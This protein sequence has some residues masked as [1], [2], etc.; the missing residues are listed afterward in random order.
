MVYMQIDNAVC[1]DNGLVRLNVRVRISNKEKGE[2]T[3]WDPGFT[4]HRASVL[5]KIQVSNPY[6]THDPENHVY[7]S[8]VE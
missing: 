4:E 5:P 6:S 1:G 7:S 8:P 3:R 2:E